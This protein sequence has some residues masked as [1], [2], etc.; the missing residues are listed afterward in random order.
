MS[1]EKQNIRPKSTSSA[2]PEQQSPFSAGF[3]TPIRPRGDP[4][5]HR[6]AMAEE[7]ELEYNQMLTERRRRN[8]QA[9]ARMRERQRMRE[10]NLKQ[11]RDELMT[12]MQQLEAELSA[13]RRQRQQQQAQMESEDCS[14]IIDKL[15]AELEG[16]TQLMGKI[17]EEIGNLVEILKSMELP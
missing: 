14:A 17:I 8:T 5:E 3:Y 15:S 13:I 9:A 4:N 7:K 11:R 6:Q 10:Q 1:S 12:R 16:A 2:I